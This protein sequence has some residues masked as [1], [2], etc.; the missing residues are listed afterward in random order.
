M[1]GA[2]ISVSP[3]STASTPT[4]SSS[5]S[6]SRRAEARLGRPPSCPRGRRRAARRCAARSTEKSLEVAV[7]EPEHVGLDVERH[8]QLAL[9]VDLDDRVEVERVR[10]A[11]QVVEIVGVQ[12]GDDQ[13]DRVRAR[14]RRLVELVAVDD[15]VL[16]QDGQLGR[17]A[18]LAQVVERAAEVERL[19]EDRQ[20]GRAAAL[21]GLHD[22]GH[23]SRPRG[24]CP[25][26]G[27]RRLCS[28]ITEMP[29]RVSASWNG[30]RLGPVGQRRLAGARAGPARGAG[31][32]SSRVSLDDALEHVHRRARAPRVSAVSASSARAAAPESTASAAAATPGLAGR[33]RGRTRRSPRRR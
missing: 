30:R 23:A 2:R 3:I 7:V 19:G 4:S 21:V 31:A 25:R 10:L 27:E 17:R 15:E 24:S 5:S 13:Q 18:R 28:A 8:L 32:T 22:L 20:R 16:A 9:V 26:D 29:G 11:Q 6:S 14:H 33:P 12:R 1:S